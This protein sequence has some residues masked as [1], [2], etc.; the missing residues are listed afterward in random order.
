M[1]LRYTRT[2]IKYIVT[3][4]CMQSVIIIARYVGLIQMRIKIENKNPYKIFAFFH[5]R[6]KRDVR[7]VR[8]VSSI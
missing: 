1:R 7:D 4:L 3:Y 5:S 8:G 2:Q 6:R